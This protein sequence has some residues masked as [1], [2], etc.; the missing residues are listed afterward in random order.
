M[1]SYRFS[2]ILVII[3]QFLF[4]IDTTAIHR[5]GG[6]IS[7]IQVGFL[8]SIG[9]M[10]LV[11]CLAPAL[12]WR[13]FYTQ[14]PFLQAARAL[15]TVGYT[16]VLILGYALM[17]LSDA[18][19]IGYVSGLYVVLLA[20]P[21][22]GEVVGLP[23]YAAVAAGIAGAVMIS[24]PGM[25]QVSWIYLLVLGGN[26][27]N[28]MAVILTKYLRRDDHATTIL[29]YVSLAQLLVF[30]PGVVEPWHFSP[31][32]WPW[33]VA[34]TITGPLGMFCGI[35]ALNYA[36]ASVLAPYGYIR[37]VIAILVASF[38]F[39]ERF[40]LF[41]IIGS[42]IIIAACWYVARTV[43]NRKSGEPESL[44]G[45]TRRS[46]PVTSPTRSIFETACSTKT[47]EG[48]LA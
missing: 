17:P 5:L 14:H 6:S 4:A 29:L 41:S 28:A 48:P 36:D 20:G 35:I 30:A 15:F 18:T 8:R 32:L 34:L 45:S 11:F 31:P 1:R 9:G 16:W 2:I 37:L 25:S 7:L 3:Q 46:R 33:I 22:L 24:R 44:S 27:L 19:A 42:C 12:G 47:S 40:D 10:A 23:R 26:I 38:V 39:N 43:P 21:L 13:V